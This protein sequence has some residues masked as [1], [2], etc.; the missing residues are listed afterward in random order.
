MKINIKVV[1]NNKIEKVEICEGGSLKVWIKAKPIEGKA[2]KRVVE[3]LSKHFNVS[4]HNVNIVLGKMSSH[5]VIE[6]T[7]NSN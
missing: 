6:I 2:N 3:V 5:K 1:P 4:K 7:E